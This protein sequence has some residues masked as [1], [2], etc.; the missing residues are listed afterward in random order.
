MILGLPNGYDTDIGQR[1][2][3]LSGGQAQRVGIARALYGEPRLVVLDEPNSNLDSDRGR[4]A[5]DHA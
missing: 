5:P 1:G 2:L 3:R 4:S